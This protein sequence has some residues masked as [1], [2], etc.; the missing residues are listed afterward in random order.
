MSNKKLS[1]Y[2]FRKLQKDWYKR[3]DES[4]F[5]DIER[6]AKSVKT[7]LMSIREYYKN[8]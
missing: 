1:K 6:W 5:V 4:G 2:A 7:V 8:H 3:L